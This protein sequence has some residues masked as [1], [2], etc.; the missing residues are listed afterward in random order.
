MQSG[1]VI[2]DCRGIR[3]QLDSTAPVDGSSPIVSDRQ[4]VNPVRG[5]EVSQV[6]GK[7]GHRDAPYLEVLRQPLDRSSSS[8][9]SDNGLDGDVDR[10]KE[11]QPQ[12]RVTLLV[13]S[14]GVFELSRRLRSETD[15]RAHPAS[16]SASR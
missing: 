14:C 3:S 6:V 13:P 7:P 10:C 16:S 2:W 1:P 12:A 9:R 11:G 5:D 15:L 4:D 8:R